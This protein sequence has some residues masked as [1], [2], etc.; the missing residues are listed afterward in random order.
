MNGRIEVENKI[1]KKIEDKI[2]KL[3]TIFDAFYNYLESDRK[4]YSTCERY[5]D[6]VYDFM[7]YITHG[8]YVEDFYKNVTVTDVRT[9]ISSLR[10][11]MVLLQT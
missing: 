8:E 5:I 9:Y 11:R 2:K 10:R 7:K 3:P 6:Y 1:Q 4:S